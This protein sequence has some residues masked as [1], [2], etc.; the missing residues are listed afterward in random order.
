M[1]DFLELYR[2]L[3]S[4]ELRP[5][6]LAAVFVFGACIGSFL[7]VCIWRMP[8][9]ESIVFAPSH[10][11]GCH[12]RIKWYDNIPLVSYLVLA[13]RCRSCHQRYTSRYFWIELATAVIF[14]L[15]AWR[16]GGNYAVLPVA[17]AAAATLIVCGVTD[18]EHGMIPDKMTGFL[19]AA[20]VAD[21]LLRTGWTE[22]R[23]YLAAAAGMFAVLSMV[24]LA[25]KKLAGRTALGWGDVKLLSVFMLVSGL[26]PGLY[27]TI[28]AS[29]GGMV[30]G[31]ARALLTHRKLST[32]EVRFGT[33]IALAGLGWLL[34]R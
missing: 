17:F 1:N 33:F 13:G 10:C 6:F 5:V 2:P 11:T 29:M 8:Q 19:L 23:P 25:G 7:N 4:P 16:S 24:A 22:F 32:A 27:V 3:F 12:A 30:F 14:T 26:L 34:L 20:A 15:L 18:L 9:K 28:A 31:L 21:G